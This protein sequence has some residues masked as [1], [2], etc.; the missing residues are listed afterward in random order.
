MSLLSPSKTGNLQHLNVTCHMGKRKCILHVPCRKSTVF[1]RDPGSHTSTLSWPTSAQQDV[2][3]LQY[4]YFNAETLRN[5]G[6]HAIF[7]SWE[8]IADMSESKPS[9]ADTD[10]CASLI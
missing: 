6:A 4:I 9:S 3:E 2:E 7:D 5:F 10:S 8:L 1:T